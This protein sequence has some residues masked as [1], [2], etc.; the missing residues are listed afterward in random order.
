[1][2]DFTF[3]LLGA[4]VSIPISILSPFITVKIQ[5]WRARRSSIQSNIR[6]GILEKDLKEAEEYK[7]D[8]LKFIAFIG[9]RILVLNAIWLL[10]GIPGFILSFIINAMLGINTIT[11]IGL[12]TDPWVNALNLL[13]AVMYIPLATLLFRYSYQTVRVAR[14]VMDIEKFRTQINAEV[15]TLKSAYPDVTLEASQVSASETPPTEPQKP[16]S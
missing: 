15:A 9:Y 10:I 12:I 1:M 7:K 4:L 14:R 2:N 13:D 11:T 8:P 6:R 3:F 5:R 16:A